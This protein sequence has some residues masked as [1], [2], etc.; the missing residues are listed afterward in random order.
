MARADD[1]CVHMTSSGPKQHQ[2]MVLA[3]ASGHTLASMNSISSV[4]L[5]SDVSSLARARCSV[6]SE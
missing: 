4:R 2:V 5:G 1:E 3:R 6:R